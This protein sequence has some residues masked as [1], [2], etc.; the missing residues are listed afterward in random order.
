MAIQFPQSRKEIYDRINTDIKNELPAANPQLRETF[1]SAF[2]IAF[3]GRDFEIYTQLQELLIDL[4]PDTARNIFADRWGSFKAI[5]RNPAT[6]S[7]GYVTFTG[8]PTT[9]IPQETNLQSPDGLIFVTLES[10]QINSTNLNISLLTRIGNTATAITTEN[11]NFASNITVTISGADQP[12]YN[13]TTTINVVNETTFEYQISGTPATP[14]TGT[15]IAT[16]NYASISVESEDNGVQTNLESGTALVITSPIS[17]IDN[18]VYVQSGGLSGGSDIESDEDYRI[19]YREIY[20]NPIAHFNVA[21]IVHQA[22]LVSGVTRVFVL[23]ITPVIGEVTIYFMRDNDPYPIPNGQAII[24]VKDELLKIKP[25]NMSDDMVH[26]DAPTPISVDFVFTAI[27]P[28]T[29]ALRLAVEE[30]L[31]EFFREIPEVGVSLSRDG[32]RSAI[33]QT[34]DPETGEFIRSFTLSEPIGDITIADGEIAL[35]GN[36]T[37]NI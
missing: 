9:I 16:A 14:A 1:L 17:G 11:H 35:L 34:F 32:Y 2:S 30:N 24:D 21:D 7:G 37:W 31:V 5:V 15:I 6:P 26:V 27:T 20:A 29:A 28:D 36:I 3:A 22:K 10:G 13:I 18:I 25:A 8:T 12:E 33:W 23:E 4:F 19:R